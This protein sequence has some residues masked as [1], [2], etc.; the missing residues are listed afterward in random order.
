M[1]AAVPVA[2][3]IAGS[4][5]SARG[6][7]KAAKSAKGPQ[8]PA[9]FQP[10]I[11]SALGT[12]NQGLQGNFPGF[13]GPFVSDLVNQGGLNTALQ[14]LTQGAETGLDPNELSRIRSTFAPMF[15]S[16]RDQL[17]AGIRQSQAA[18]G[19]Y[20]GSGG[21]QQENLGLSDLIN[22]QES[23]LIPLA[24]QSAALRYQAASQIPGLFQGGL[25]ALGFPQAQGLAGLSSL[26]SGTPFYNPVSSPNS[27]QI[28][29]GGL[30][31][32][33]ASP[34]FQSL[35]QKKG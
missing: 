21:I 8:I 35:F 2:T 10:A 16:Q 25:Q 3:S 18:R 13:G 32:L 12:I 7:K 9:Q 19:I 22:K 5:I 24:Q 27:G 1:P 11:N 28:I 4:A 29:G 23:S 33:A 20:F 34:G 17:V 14:A 31:N 26:L 6:S 30:A 15:Q